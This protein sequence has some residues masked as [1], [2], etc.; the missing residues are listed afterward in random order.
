MPCI[1]NVFYAAYD[2]PSDFEKI[3][4]EWLSAALCTEVTSFKTRLCNDGRVAVTA[5]LHD[6]VYATPQVDRP[7]SLAIKMQP[8]EEG[9][10]QLGYHGGLFSQ[11]LYFFTTFREKLPGV[12]AP[13]ILGIWSEGG[14]PGLDKIEFFAIMMED[15]SPTY[16]VYSITT[17]PS[18]T[19]VEN[20]AVKA[21]APLHAGFWNKVDLAELPEL[22]PGPS[23]LADF[24]MTIDIFAE[25]WPRVRALW[26]PKAKFSGPLL[27]SGFPIAWKDGIALLDKL[28][29]PGVFD[30]YYAA[31]NDVWKSRVQ[32]S[33]HGD[34]NVGNIWRSKA[35]PSHH[36]L[37]DW[38][39]LR[40]GPVAWE[41]TTPQIGA[42]TFLLYM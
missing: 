20:I 13:K 1:S 38:Q 15:L 27:D 14:R 10:R 29:T 32:T 2:G 18:A 30:K 9:A 35:D 6:I 39:L 33:V 3:S 42:R 11:E 40:M 36:L 22:D 16:D 21:F 24:T 26:P 4:K 31:A 7:S 41:F 28:A 5:V 34:M 23:L 8:A 25:T 19:D 17:T 37:A 12:E